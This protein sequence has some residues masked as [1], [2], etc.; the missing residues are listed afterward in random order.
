MN[1]TAPNPASAD[2]RTAGEPEI[3]ARGGAYYRNTR[4]IFSALL[5]AMAAWFGYD[6][7]V[8]Y[9]RD[10]ELH[11]L[12]VRNPEQYPKDY[13]TH[14]PTSILIQKALA[15]T[16]PFAGFWLIGWT[17]YRS[18][19]AYRL[20]GDVLSVPGHPDVPLAAITT[21]DKSKWDRKGIAKIDYEL[22][23]GAKGKLT[24]DDFIYDRPPTDRILETIEAKLGVSASPTPPATEADASQSDASR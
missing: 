19:G 14:D 8:T 22:P 4:F 16:L 9:P 3:V 10:N 13:P 15:A 23:T 24:L 5:L 21:I 11:L 2:S 20:A 1:D 12:H 18:R 6:G 7:F 17:L